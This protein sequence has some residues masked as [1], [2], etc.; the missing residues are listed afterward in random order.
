MNSRNSRFIAAL[1][2]LQLCN[3]DTI[4]KITTPRLFDCCPEQLE[5]RMV[6]KILKRLLIWERAAHQAG[7]TKLDGS[8]LLVSFLFIP[9]NTNFA[10]S[11][12]FSANV[13]ST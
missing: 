10:R 12:D 5:P 9:N 13:H 2:S 3:L 1:F 8:R 6:F 7:D 11:G 4:L